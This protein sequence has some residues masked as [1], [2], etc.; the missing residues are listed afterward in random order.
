[1]ENI[2]R[3]TKKSELFEKYES[4]VWK[5]V[6]FEDMIRRGGKKQYSE[7]KLSQTFSASHNAIIFISMRCC[8]SSYPVYRLKTTEF[9][10]YSILFA[11]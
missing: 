1:M 9:L 5:H 2:T 8:V 6:G 10:F 7:L 4:D 3:V 11:V